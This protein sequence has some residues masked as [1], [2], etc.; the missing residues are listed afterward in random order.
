[1]TATEVVDVSAKSEAPPPVAARRRQR[2]DRLA[3]AGFTGPAGVVLAMVF[4][5][6]VVYSIWNSFQASG[7]DTWGADFVGGEH[8]ADIV[9]SDDFWRAFMVSAVFTAASVTGAY[10]LGLTVAVLVDS[11]TPGSR[12]LQAVTIVPWAMPH[13]AA[14][15]LWATIFD[16]QYGPANWL[17]QQ[18]GVL[19]DQ[20][21]WLTDGNLALVSVTVVQIWM[22]FPLAGVMLLAGLQAIPKERYESA[23]VDGANGRQTLRYVTLPGL[24]S[25]TTVLL[26]LMMIWVFGR[27]FTAIYVLTGGGP[28]GA[29]RNLVVQVFHTAFEQFDFQAASALGTLVLLFSLVLTLVYRRFGFRETET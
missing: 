10:L 16:Y 21:G 8:Y 11:K 3:L 1:M 17:L 6:P 7:T 24:R 19:G 28:A 14:A 22:L 5:L 4:L 2:R 25:V 12:T 15:M 27:S 26:L 20:A 23:A 29:T 9:N 13:V 18:S